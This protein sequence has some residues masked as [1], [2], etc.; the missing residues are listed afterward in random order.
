MVLG[1]TKKQN[2]RPISEYH[3]DMSALWEEIEGLNLLPALTQMSPEVN[4]FIQ[5]M[6]RQREEQHLFQFLNVLDEEY[7]PQRSHHAIFSTK[8]MSSMW[9]ITSR[10]STQRETLNQMLLLCI[11]N[12]ENPGLK[13]ETL[14]LGLVAQCV[15]GKTT[16]L[17]S[18]GELLDFLKFILNTRSSRETRKQWVQG[19]WNKPNQGH[20]LAV[21]AHTFDESVSL[22]ATQPEQLLKVVPQV[23][24]LPKLGMKLRRS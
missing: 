23:L 3:A 21:N 11:T 14:N 9:N 2:E 1:N 7:A 15:E 13:G 5:A 16:P 20:K 4:E 12:E 6:N 10:R 24:S 22:T 8:C 18:A 17:K 19:R